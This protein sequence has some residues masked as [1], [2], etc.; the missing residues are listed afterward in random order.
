MEITGSSLD[1]GKAKTVD[2]PDISPS[3]LETLASLKLS[4]K[5]LQA[6]IDDLP[7]SADVKAFLYQIAGG[8][9]RV[10]AAV[11]KV[12]QKVI[13]AVFSIC[14]KFPN[15]T[16]GFIFGA[17]AGSLIASI[18]ILGFVLGSVVTPL[19][20]A[21]GLMAGANADFADQALERKVKEALHTFGPLKG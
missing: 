14:E 9:V 20:M 7:L 18:P 4:K 6:K 3:L 2:I 17:I 11:I 10:G 12:G 5:E 1:T 13:E 16:F 19:L 15:T 8:V 21:L